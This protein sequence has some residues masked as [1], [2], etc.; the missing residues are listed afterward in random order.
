MS[1]IE[2]VGYALST[3]AERGSDPVAEAVAAERLGFDFV[4]SADHPVGTTPTYETLTLLTW[5]AARTE[6]IGIAAKVLAV[7][8]RRPAMVAKAAESLQRLAG[9]R[10]ILGLGGGSAD[11]EIAALGAAVPTPGDKVDGMAEAIEIMH[12]IWS[13]PD[14]T[15]AGRIHAVSNLTMTPRPDRPI[16]IW[17]G[18]YGPRALAATGR[19]ADGWIPSLGY[20]GPSEIPGMLARIRSAS[21]AAGRAPDAVRAVYNVS[22]TLDRRARRAGGTVS[23]SAADVVE[24]LLEFAD[25]GFTG[26]N[27]VVAPGQLERVAADVLPAL[28]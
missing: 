26:L 12:R 18:T 21:E 8:F 7:P 9:G 1:A 14:V 15:Y 28:R 5:V 4:A 19:L 17:L 22:L 13:G 24:Q 10:L 23:G 11:D 27:L 6:R 3:A 16:P 2:L 20:A 25:L